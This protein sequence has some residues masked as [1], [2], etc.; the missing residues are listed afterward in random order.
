[1]WR[2]LFARQNVAVGV[3]AQ[4]LDAR[5]AEQQLHDLDGTRAEQNEVAERPPPVYGELLRVVE[6]R[7]QGRFVAVYVRDDSQPH[8]GQTT[9]R[10]PA[11]NG[12][13]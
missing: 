8:A 12:T 10:L 9:Q 7:P 5:Q 11:V 3:P 2:G 6:H 4:H 1:V 13:R